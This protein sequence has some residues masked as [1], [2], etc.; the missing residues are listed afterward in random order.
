MPKINHYEAE[1]TL[2]FVIDGP[3]SAAEAATVAEERANQALD[4]RLSS[5]GSTLRALRSP[6]SRSGTPASGPFTGAADDLA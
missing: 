3:L 1:V 6:P 2:R 5:S 4:A